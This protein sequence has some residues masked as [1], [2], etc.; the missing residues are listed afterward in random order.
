[1]ATVI[2]SWYEQACG[3]KFINAVY[4][5]ARGFVDIVAQFEGNGYDEDED[6]DL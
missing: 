3:L 5:D 2:M 4:S 1:M 6:E